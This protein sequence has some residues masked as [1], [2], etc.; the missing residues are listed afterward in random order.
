MKTETKK[1]YD[2]R[3]E[4]NRNEYKDAF[5]KKLDPFV[6]GILDPSDYLEF[7]GKDVI[8]TGEQYGLCFLPDSIHELEEE[9]K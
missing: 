4:K 2:L 7:E 6:T 8:C 3:Y 9:D 5:G 1:F